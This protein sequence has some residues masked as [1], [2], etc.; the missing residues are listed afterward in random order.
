MKK[1][2]FLCLLLAIA[3]MVGMSSCNGCSKSDKNAPNKEHVTVFTADYDGVL[4]DLSDG[5]EHIIALHRQTMNEITGGKPYAWYEAKFT[6]ADTLKQETLLDATVVEV[7]DVFQTVNP[8]LCYFLTT[9]AVKGTLIPAP[10]P[11]LWIEDFDL[12]DCEVKLTIKDALARLA[13]VNMP[14]PDVTSVVLRKPV[15]PK[16]CNAQYVA[17]TAVRAV[18]VDAVTGNVTDMCPTR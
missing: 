14:I 3:C 5:A 15:G 2:I 4:P 8:T 13:E 1:N 6:L 7:T 11:G 12:S 16:P 17:G 10:T 18:W 9:N